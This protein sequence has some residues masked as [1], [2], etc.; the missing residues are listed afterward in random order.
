MAKSLAKSAA[1]S[2]AAD[3]RIRQN[4]CRIRNQISPVMAK[5]RELLPSAKQAQH[6]QILTDLPL[7][8]CQKHLC[9]Q[10][11]DSAALLTRLL[12]S[13]MG[14]DVLMVLV[15]GCDEDW[16]VR[17]RKQLDLNEAR[18]QLAAN[19][20]AIEALQAEIGR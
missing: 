18:R 11:P 2:S 17:Y 14:R 8:T 5:V 15:D 6:L 12:R 16:I 3:C 1:H 20:K 4:D 7:S 9:G 10:L 19:Q 13:P